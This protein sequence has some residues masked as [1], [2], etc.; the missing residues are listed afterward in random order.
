PFLQNKKYGCLPGVVY[1]AVLLVLYVFPWYNGLR[2]VNLFGTASFFAA[3]YIVDKRNVGQKAFLAVTS[4]LLKWITG[5]FESVLW[6]MLSKYFL[7]SPY[8]TGK[9]VLSLI[10]FGVL[11]LVSCVAGFWIQIFFCSII[12]R[13]YV[14]KKEDMTGRELVLILSPLLVILS[15]YFLFSYWEKAYVHDFKM[16]IEDVHPAYPWLLLCYQALSFAAMLTTIVIY[17]NIKEVRRKERENAVLSKEMETMQRHINEVEALYRDIRGL[18]H[19]MGN[20]VMILENL[21]AKGERKEAESYLMRLKEQGNTGGTGIK[22]GN[23]VTDVILMEKKKEAEAKGILFTCDFYYPQETQINAFD[24]SVILHNALDN[25][26]EGAAHCENSYIKLCSH[27]RKNAYLI[28]V[29]NSL[30]GEVVINE[31]SG[32]PETTKEGSGEHGYGLVNIKQVA[33]RYF[34]DIDIGQTG[35][36]FKLTVLLMLA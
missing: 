24:I 5:G 21:L 13:A 19:D 28:E 34:G 18:K 1:A 29:S 31:E 3:M 9:A 14:C 25:A 36:E 10:V 17:Q 27:R 35:E 32:L 4:Y 8:L 26:I 30:A 12:N 16:Y 15:G 2:I 23:L 11:E 7:M 6:S 20:H 22:S 33:A